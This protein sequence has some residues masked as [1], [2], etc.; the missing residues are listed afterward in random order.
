MVHV[1]SAIDMALWDIAGK[2]YQ[3]PVYRLLGGPAATRCGCILAPRRSG[4]PW[5]RAISRGD[6]GRGG[7]VGAAGGRRAR[8]GGAGWGGDVR[9]A[10]H[11]AAAASQAVCRLSQA[12][13]FAL[14]GRGVGTGQH[15]GHAQAAR[16]RARAVGDRR[17]RPHHLGG[18][19]DFGGL[20]SSISCSPTAATAAASA[21]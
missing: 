16:G 11:V 8:Q 5:G 2:L 3:V 20:R 12:G 10:Q 9:C 18:A 13:R 17:A 21:R 6:A 15:R 14:F 4:R 19:R 7:G 1:I